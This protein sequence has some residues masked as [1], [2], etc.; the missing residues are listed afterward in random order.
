MELLV[1]YALCALMD[2]IFYIGHA[3]NRAILEPPIETNKTEFHGIVIKTKTKISDM[4]Y[5]EILEFIKNAKNRN[6]IN[7]SSQYS[8]FGERSFNYMDKSK[9]DVD[10]LRSFFIPYEEQIVTVHERTS[11]ENKKLQKLLSIVPKKK[12]NIIQRKCS[13][14]IDENGA[15]IDTKKYGSPL[16]QYYSVISEKYIRNE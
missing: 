10:Y 16:C 12:L 8:C 15:V 14:C 7:Y 3:T 4:D 9:K 5:E 6:E 13:L 2:G 11:T 1:I